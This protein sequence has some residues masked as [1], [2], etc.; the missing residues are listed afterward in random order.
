MYLSRR[1]IEAREIVKECMLDD[2]TICI[3]DAMASDCKGRKPEEIYK[4]EIFTYIGMGWCYRLNGILQ[5]RLPDEHAMFF[6][7]TKN[8][9]EQ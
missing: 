1:T 8:N 6:V 4:P 3:Y 7:Y 2:G 9:S 5:S